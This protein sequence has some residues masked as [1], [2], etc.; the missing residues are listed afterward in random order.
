MS[1]FSINRLTILLFI[2]ILSLAVKNY[3]C[4]KW[5]KTMNNSITKTKN[6]FA[7]QNLVL[8]ALFAAVLCVSAYISIPLPNGSH[9]TALNF[10]VTLIGLVFTIEQSFLISLVWLLLG[11][12]G[13][14]VFIG[15]QGGIGYL[16]GQYG[17]YSFAFVIIAI[18]LPVFCKRKY[19]R[20]SFT[21]AAIISA[22]FVDVFGS[23]WIMIIGGINLKAAFI[24][25][26]LP[27][28]ALDTV[29]AIV[30][31]QIAPA[32]RRILNNAIN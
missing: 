4:K 17:G 2:Y 5:R 31:A 1:T 32:F 12:V 19:N 6:V 10:V 3:N 20:I 13:V 14:P 28:I 9:I 8:M 25:G 29:K 18:L 16:F 27:F 7:T 22:I 11:A 24:A 21:I 26:F 30:A 15:G 23:I